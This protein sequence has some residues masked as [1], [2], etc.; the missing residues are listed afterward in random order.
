MLEEEG[1]GP[2]V[3]LRTVVRPL[4]GPAGLLVAVDGSPVVPP[5][6]LQLNAV[7]ESL[8]IDLTQ[9]KSPSGFSLPANVT[10]SPITVAKADF[11]LS[12]LYFSNPVPT[13]TTQAQV[14]FQGGLT[15]D[16]V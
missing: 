7:G 6:I 10:A 1:G 15:F 2:V 4:H 16:N 14:L 12:A 5:P 3:L 8:T 11:T 9:L 13:D